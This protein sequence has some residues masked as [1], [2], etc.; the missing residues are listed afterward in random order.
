MAPLITKPKSKQRADFVLKLV[1][2]TDDAFPDGSC[3]LLT[4]KSLFA[5]KIVFQ[6]YFIPPVTLM[7]FSVATI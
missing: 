5:V 1:S 3:Q 2:I 4:E 6:I 7:L